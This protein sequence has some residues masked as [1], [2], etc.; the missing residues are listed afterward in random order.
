MGNSRIVPSLK[1]ATKQVA[2]HC[3]TC[4]AYAGITI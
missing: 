1:A 3:A 2:H 4:L